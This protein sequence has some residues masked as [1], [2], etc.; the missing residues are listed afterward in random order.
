VFFGQ[1]LYSFHLIHSSLNIT[2]Y[3]VVANNKIDSRFDE[4]G[5]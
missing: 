4:I 3:A 2:T 1:L 5:N